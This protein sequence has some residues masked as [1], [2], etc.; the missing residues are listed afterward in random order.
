[1]I[2]MHISDSLHTPNTSVNTC[3]HKYAYV[4][5]YLY[6]LLRFPPLTAAAAYHL[7][8]SL[9]FSPGSHSNDC[10]SGRDLSLHFLTSQP[11]VSANECLIAPK[12][13]PVKPRS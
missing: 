2:Y 10:H 11:G 1:M 3:K 7:L 6:A 4:C 13:R 12:G 5:V 8:P 9:L